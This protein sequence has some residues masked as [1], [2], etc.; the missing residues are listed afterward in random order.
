MNKMLALEFSKLLQFVGHT[1]HSTLPSKYNG[2]HCYADFLV[3]K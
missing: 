1:S 3:E 2:L